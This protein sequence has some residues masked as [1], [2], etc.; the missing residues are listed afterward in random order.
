[1]NKLFS[2]LAAALIALTAVSVEARPL[3]FTEAASLTDR[4]ILKAGDFAWTDSVESAID[5]APVVIK[6]NLKTQMAYVY[7]G[8]TMIGITNISSGRDGYETPTGR[9]KILGKEDNHWSKKYKADMPWT[10]WVTNDGVALHSGVTPGRTSSHG[11]IHLPDA[12]AK[13]LYQ[14][15]DRGAMVIITGSDAHTELALDL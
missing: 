2:T 15:T 3:S 11:C 1:M 4:S 13:M 6:I 9:F 10:M 12:F 5:N 7:R 14:V 8:D